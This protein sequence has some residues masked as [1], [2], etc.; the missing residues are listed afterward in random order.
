MKR[1]KTKNNK[2]QLIFS[3]VLVLLFATIITINDFGLIKLIELKK[4][5]YDLQ[6]NIYV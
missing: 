3:V 5:K 1:K 2:G 6:N 4:I